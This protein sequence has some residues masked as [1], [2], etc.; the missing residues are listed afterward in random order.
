MLLSVV[1]YIFIISFFEIVLDYFFFEVRVHQKQ[2]QYVEL[3]FAYTLFF[4][5]LILWDNV[6]L[7]FFTVP[8]VHLNNLKR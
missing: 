6:H 1:F 5:D 8:E 3:R 4:S 7:F 2:P